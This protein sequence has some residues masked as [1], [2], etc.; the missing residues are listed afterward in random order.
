MKKLSII[1][2]FTFFLNPAMA[3]ERPTNLQ[4]ASNVPEKLSGLITF[5][6]YQD[7]EAAEKF[8]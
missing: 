6:F 4:Q 1:I 3:Q 7:V 5:A 2:L 8:M